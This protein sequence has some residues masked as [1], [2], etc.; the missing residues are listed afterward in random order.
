MD[1]KCLRC[2]EPVEDRLDAARMMVVDEEGSRLAFMHRECA[3][4]SVIGG[5]NHLRGTCTCC[6]GTDDPDPPEM[7]K[8]QAAIAAVEYWRAKNG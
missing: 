2:E 7:T 4:R 8:R 5:L 6:G 3:R 1:D